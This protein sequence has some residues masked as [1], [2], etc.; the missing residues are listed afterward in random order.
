MLQIIDRK[1]DLV[2]L[3][4][5][6]YVAL[7]KVENAL[8]L[9]AYV[10]NCLCYA[11]SSAS[12]T[13]ALV[14]VAEP[15]LRR[16][17]AAAKAAGPGVSLAELCADPAVVAEVTKAVKAAAAPKLAAFELPKALLLLSAPWT[18][19]SDFLTAAMKLKRQVITKAFA[20][21]LATLYKA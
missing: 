14:V 8:K 4:M 16:D 20:T 2:K 10:D 12:H 5:G 19:E 21:E 18:P 7:S 6:E 17:C 11:L 1:K 13:V 9:S 15:A 3:Q